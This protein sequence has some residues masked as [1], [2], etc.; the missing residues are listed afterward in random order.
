LKAR[1][2]AQKANDHA[3]VAAI[4]SDIN[5]LGGLSRYQQASQTGQLEA[6]GG[7]TSK[8][9][10]EWLDESGRSSDPETIRV[11]EVGCLSPD[12][13][14]SKIPAVDMVRID[15]NSTHPSIAEQDFMQLALPTSESEKFDIISLS[16]VL[17]FVSEPNHRGE[18]L[19]R[20]TKFMK[21]PPENKSAREKHLPALFLVL[22]LPCVANS[23]YLT[24]D[25]LRAIMEGIGYCLSK[26][27]SSSKIFYSLWQ[28]TGVSTPVNF[29]KRELVA[30]RSR[31]NFCVSINTG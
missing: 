13:A 2:V 21:L 16:L 29:K 12:N 26:E 27:K 9:L 30:G 11:L 1:S 25:H 22:P 4:D 14:I 3:R 18:M 15:L 8:I 19:L 28:Y 24:R 6:R 20:T 7:D 10:I 17:N 31:N 23:R 5:N